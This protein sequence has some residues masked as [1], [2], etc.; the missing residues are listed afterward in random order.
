MTAIAN[1]NNNNKSSVRF[2]VSLHRIIFDKQDFQAYLH[3]SFG[4]LVSDLYP[5][6]LPV[7]LLRRVPAKR[8]LAAVLQEWYLLTIEHLLLIPLRFIRQQ[9]LL[10]IPSLSTTY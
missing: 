5:G 2:Q 8:H 6:A 1:I 10:S 7:S 9:R 3:I 4:M